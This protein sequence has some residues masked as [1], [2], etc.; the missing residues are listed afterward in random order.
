[1]F[2]NKFKSLYTRFTSLKQFQRLAAIVVVLIVAGIGTYLLSSSH[3]ASPYGSADAD[4]GSLTGVANSQACTGAD[5]GNCVQFGSSSSTW[6]CTS[7]VPT[8]SPGNYSYINGCPLAWPGPYYTDTT[9]LTGSNSAGHGLPFSGLGGYA[10]DGGDWSPICADS[11]GGIVSP[12][13]SN[14]VTPETQELQANSDE[15][16]VIT[17]NTPTDPTG[18]VSGFPNVGTYSYTGPVDDYATLTSSYTESQ[19]ISSTEGGT[20]NANTQGW[21]ML[22]SYYTEPGNP[23]WETDYEVS[24][25]FDFSGSNGDCPTT[26][27]Q[28]GGGTGWNYGVVANDINID[29]TLWHLCEGGTNH[30]SSGACQT[31][32]PECGQLVFH[33]GC[34]DNALPHQTTASGTIDIKAMVQWLE[35]HDMPQSSGLSANQTWGSVADACSNP[36][37]PA[38]GSPGT[39]ASYP[40]VTPGSS[41]ATFSLGWEIVSTGGVPEQYSVNKWTVNATGTPAACGTTCP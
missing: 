25:Q 15:D 31:A 10:I 9:N 7:N 17:N 18:A 2:K 28:N 1:M 30:Q 37:Q 8:G 29:G 33:E 20:S 24:I 41:A 21:A 35:D 13:A 36:S 38:T 23:D 32:Y 26:L 12:N 16:F 11:T 40:Y 39:Y 5:D 3:A 14:C 19:P 4:T 22:E 6:A 34:D 27:A